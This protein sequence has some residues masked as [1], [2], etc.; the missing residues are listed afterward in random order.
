MSEILGVTLL[1]RESEGP[2]DIL[3]EGERIAA[4]RRSA[5]P[6]ARRRLALP[7][8][9][10]AHDHCRPLSPTS[11]GG[12]DKP[13][14]LWL[15]RLAA[16]P[17]VDPYLAALA[18]F[19]RAARGGAG[20]VM[21]HYTRFHRPEDPVA[22][23][24]ALAQAASEVGVRVTLA[25]FMRDRNPI[26]YGRSEDLLDNLP[27][28]SR[29]ALAKYFGAPMQSPAEQIARVEAIAAA[30]ES[31]TFSVQFGPNGAQWCS[32]E[33]LSAIAEASAR[34][35][36][37]VHM[38]FLETLYQRAFADRQYP[39]GIAVRL[40][41][42]GLMSPRLTLAHCVHAREEE[43]DAIARCG[44]TIAT[45]PSS[46]LHLRSGIAPIG[47]AIRRGARVALG[48]DAS[49]FDEDDDILREMR[50][51]HFLHA[52]WG[53]ANGVSRQDWLAAVLAN[54]RRAN[55]A[56]GSGA[57][58]V[59]AARRRAGARSRPARPR[60]RHAGR[61]DRPVVRARHGRACRLAL[62]RRPRG[63]RRRPPG[64]RRPRS[65][66]RRSC[67]RN[68]ANACATAPTSSTPGGQ[69]PRRSPA[70]TDAVETRSIVAKTCA[71]GPRGVWAALDPPKILPLLGA[72]MARVT[73]EDCIDK[74]DNRFELVLM[75]S[76]RARA[77][78]SGSSI[79]VARDNDKNPVV[80]LREIADSK[81]QPSDL[82]EDVIHALQK[83]V[84]VDEPEAEAAPP[85]APTAASLD[86]G[87]EAQFDRMTEEDL[88]RGLEGM[89]PPPEPEDDA[90]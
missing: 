9:A 7:A 76:H 49:A 73:V 82:R 79:L 53:F 52:G 29:T 60:R 71:C 3:I 47:E 83:Q 21:A 15:L 26:V 44:V 2:V 61:A 80:A 67:A 23:A 20:S 24:R 51:G 57:L 13:L 5:S 37:R 11:F 75:A 43:L 50:L 6:P 81:L 74:V 85:L 56:P 77:I 46:N 4:L 16:M 32:D 87:A 28:P 65:D 38:H 89:A 90:E 59:G 62:R 33:L 17:A 35:G 41:R 42:L 88:L 8:L 55:G 39:E 84:E 68:I 78:S 34:S 54:G 31:P 63:G 48:V 1:G 45:N 12:A 36:R 19:G 27:A 69:S 66:A 22:E 58:E 72:V 30:V 64:R 18:A 70:I 14:E 10:N 40:E 86:P 25:V